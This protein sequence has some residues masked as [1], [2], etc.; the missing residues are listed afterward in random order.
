MALRVRT[1]TDEEAKEIQRLSRS[2]TEPARR[3]ERTV[4]RPA[5]PGAGG[6][7]PPRQAA[8]IYARTGRRGPARCPDEAEGAGPAFWQLD[9]GPLGGLSQTQVATFPQP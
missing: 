9:A 5:P 6:P 1:L 3:V 2:R 4:Q 8:D 7:P